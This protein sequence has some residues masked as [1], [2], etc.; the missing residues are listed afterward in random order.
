MKNKNHFQVANFERRKFVVESAKGLAGLA[1]SS[2]TGLGAILPN[3]S[4]AQ[5]SVVNNLSCVPVPPLFCVAYITPNAPGQEGQEAMVARYP[6][7]IVPQD[8]RSIFINWRN[9]IKSINPSI[10]FVG[11]Q[12]T[13]EETTVPGP[14]HDRLRMITNSWCK[15]PDGTIP[16]VGPSTK[17]RRIYDPRTEEWQKGFI[18]S[19][20]IVLEAYPYS[21]LFLDQCSVFSIAH[22][23][24]SVRQEMMIALQK[25]LL[26]LR[27]KFPGSIIIGNSRYNWDGL[28]GEMNEDLSESMS[29]ELVKHPGHAS[30]NIDMHITL[31]KDEN[32]IETAKRNMN[33]AHSYGAFYGAAV[34]YQRVLWFDFFDEVIKACKPSIQA[35][36]IR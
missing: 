30:P 3:A 15:Y 31:L 11:Y 18:E 20:G 36:I 2:F 17:K 8:N 23:D 14:G 10:L 16:T 21:G 29:K 7:A 4:L 6:L 34:N 28:N 1:I 26:A 27:N 22:P 25:T 32:D 5:S 12:M 24:A 35:P 33:I 19:C 13:I 9:N